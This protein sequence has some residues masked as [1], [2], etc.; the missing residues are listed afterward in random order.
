VLRIFTW[1]SV[2]AGTVISRN[3]GAGGGGG[4]GGAAGGGGGIAPSLAARAV[5]G[6]AAGA[7]ADLDGAALDAAAG[8]SAGGADAGFG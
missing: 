2:P 7:A 5:T 4:G 8:A 1:I 3:F 6:E